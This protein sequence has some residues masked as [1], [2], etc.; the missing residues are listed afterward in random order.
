VW[1]GNKIFRDDIWGRLRFPFRVDYLA[2]KKFGAYDFPQKNY[3]NRVQNTTMLLLSKIPAFR[4]KVKKR[5]KEEMIKPLQKE[6]EK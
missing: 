1:G 3:K 4:K 6:L 5:M 2:Y